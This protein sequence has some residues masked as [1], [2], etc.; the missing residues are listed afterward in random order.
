MSGSPVCTNSTSEKTSRPGEVIFRRRPMSD[1]G[2]DCVKTR[3]LRFAGAAGWLMNPS[4]CPD[5]LY[6]SAD[7]ENHH[8]AF[9][10]VGKDV[11]RHFGADVLQ[12]LHWKC[13][14]P[15]QDFMVPNGCSTVSRRRRIL[16][17]LR[18]SPVLD[19]LENGF[20]LPTGDPTL[21][22]RCALALHVSRFGKRLSNSGVISCLLPRSYSDT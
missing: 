1:V 4:L 6:Q 5:R 20:M 15:I 7:A 8:H 3:M 21:L 10:V 12:R 2:P 19:G 18:S 9:H 22:T 17:G 11:Q 13:V 14:D 16:S